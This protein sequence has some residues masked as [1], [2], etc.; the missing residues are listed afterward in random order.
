MSM[1]HQPKSLFKSLFKSSWDLISL[2]SK[3]EECFIHGS[4][5]GLDLRLGDSKGPKI[6]LLHLV[7]MVA[8]F[9]I[10]GPFWKLGCHLPRT[11]QPRDTW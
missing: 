11:I 9:A 3:V 10:V 6:N 4:G 1:A 5:S 8:Q 2:V 7:Q